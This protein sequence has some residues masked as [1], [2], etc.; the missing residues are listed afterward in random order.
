MSALSMLDTIRIAGPWPLK[1]P[2]PPGRLLNDGVI[3]LRT[4]PDLPEVRWVEVSLAR[5]FFGHNGQVLAN[6]DEID[7]ALER[8]ETRLNPLVP[9]PDLRTCRLS[10]SDLAWN[11]DIQ[12]RALIRAHSAVR[13]P[14]IRSGATLHRDGQGVSWWGSRSRVKITLYDKARERHVP[15]SVLRAEVS[16]AGSELHRHFPD[17]TWYRFEHQYQVFRE[18]LVTIPP[19]PKPAPGRGW[20]EAIA[21]EPPEVRER[22]LAR[23][24][25]KPSATF[26][27]W[28][29]RI[30]AAAARLPETFSWAELLP[31][32]G[33]PPAVTVQAK[34]RSAANRRI[35]SEIDHRSSDPIDGQIAHLAAST[36][37]VRSAAP[38]CEEIQ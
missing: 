10:R 19:I 17:Q 30:E 25:H 2:L 9:V 26:R 38:D 12:A 1:R 31:V 8:L 36:T 3:K 15:G 21:A 7:A 37:P 33:P 27:R 35:S 16:L 24:V 5:L 34:A 22:I 13:V 6:Q 23:L 32:S 28:R 29:R 4:D 11:F 20:Q 14:G 18:I